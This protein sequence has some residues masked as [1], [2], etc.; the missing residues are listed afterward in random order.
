MSRLNFTICLLFTLVLISCTDGSKKSEEVV[1]GFA[2]AVNEQ[3][4]STMLKYY[5]AAKPFIQMI[6]QMGD[7]EISGI[8]AKDSKY[9]VKCKTGFYDENSKFVQ[10][11]VYFFIEKVDAGFVITDSKGLIHLPADLGNYPYNIG[12]ITKY[13][14]DIEIGTKGEDIMACF[15]ADWLRHVWRIN[16][17]IETISWSWETN[18]GTPN[19]K[20]TIKN[21]LPFRVSNVKYKITYYNGNDIIGSDDGTAASSIDAGGTKSFSFYSSGVNGY[22]VRTA[23]IE[24]EVPERYAIEWTLNQ[25]FTGNEFEEYKN[26]HSVINTD[27]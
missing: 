4:S 13:S 22:L 2:N 26:I 25:S 5:P 10:H 27:I 12:A 15:Y 3:D 8:E 20:C 19:G 16:S 23:H 6:D 9:T 1:K 18:W 11:D 7:V 21:T 24:F 17:G 14:K